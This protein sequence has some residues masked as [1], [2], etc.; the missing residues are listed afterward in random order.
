VTPNAA[1][2]TLTIP[3]APEYVG[4]ARLTIMSVASRMGFSVDMIEDI[5]MA[6]GEACTN[7][8]ERS[9]RSR[10]GANGPDP[11]I[12]IRSRI[13]PSRL[14]I[15][16]EDHIPGG[17][18]I[19]PAPDPGSDIELYPL[20]MGILVDEVTIEP[21]AGGGTQVR[22]VKYANSDADSEVSPGNAGHSVDD[23]T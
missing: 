15:E 3:C 19:E 5:R 11:E 17:E 21:L 6:V 18:A 14:L 13:E 12:T 4:M 7:A 9:D 10:N 1:L 2:V 23:L 8:I 16:V 22:L 20:L